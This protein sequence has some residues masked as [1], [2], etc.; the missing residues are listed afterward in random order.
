MFGSAGVRIPSGWRSH[1]RLHGRG[2]PSVR[3][4]HMPHLY[5][6]SDH[7]DADLVLAA[8]VAAAVASQDL[9]V[10]W[11]H[12]AGAGGAP[13]VQAV[14]HEARHPSHPVAEILRALRHGMA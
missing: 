10:S 8:D 14:V 11:T 4:P 2:D 13:E 12:L 6:P 1:E 3:R 9:Y 5:L 7:S